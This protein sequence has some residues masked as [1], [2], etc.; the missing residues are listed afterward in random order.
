MNYQLVDDMLNNSMN[1]IVIVL[2]LSFMFTI[3]MKTLFRECRVE[4][5]L[6]MMG[7]LGFVLV[8]GLFTRTIS[9]CSN[10]IF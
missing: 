5:S 2:Y 1:E 7:K 6:K 9:I 10:I 8:I 3:R 4:S